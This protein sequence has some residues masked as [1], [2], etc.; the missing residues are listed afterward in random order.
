MKKNKIEQLKASLSPYAFHELLGGLDMQNLTEAERFYLKNYGIYNI[1]LRPENFMIRLRITAGRVDAARLEYIVDVAESFA[2]TPL[3]TARAQLE[4]HGLRADNVLYAWEMLREGGVTTLQTL[5]DNFRNIVTDPLDGRA[6]E[7]W[8][9]VYAL[10]REMESFFLGEKA[11]MGMLPRKFNIAVTANPASGLHF[12]GND[13]FFAPAQKEGRFGFNLYLGGKN[14]EAAKCANIFV[15]AGES[16]AMFRAVAQAYMKYGLRGSRSKTRLFHLLQVMGM[17]LFREKIAHFYGGKLEAAGRLLKG[18][19]LSFHEVF[20]PLKDGSYAYRYQSRFGEI[21]TKALREIVTF[22][23]REEVEVRFGIDQNIYLLGLQAPQVPF[24]EAPH[25]RTRV[26]ACAGSRY[27]ALSLWDIKEETAYLPLERLARHNIS[28]GFSG[29]L[30]GCGRH[31][32][33]D[34]G[35]V[36]LRTNLFGP[37]VKAARLFLGTEYSH[38]QKPARLIF[39]VVPLAKLSSLIDVI[40]DEFE[41]SGERDFESFS[42]NCLNRYSTG[43]LMLWFLSKRYLHEVITF[44]KRDE[45][46]LYAMLRQR[47]DYPDVEEKGGGYE[48]AVRTMMHALWDLPRGASSV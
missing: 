27:C 8:M 7:S 10:V 36:G 23:K 13:L 48:A 44:E 17:A 39:H 42:R 37:V 35:L 46:T 26:T 31:H 32:H 6:R 1:K 16:V 29:C 38:T 34:I 12:F 28:V 14:S 15:P 20:V 21:S 33:E 41:A 2:A 5:T 4:L 3:L 30:K 40:V 22:V 11:W 45:Q 9:E 25:C 18:E 19:G 47:V 24:E 43:F